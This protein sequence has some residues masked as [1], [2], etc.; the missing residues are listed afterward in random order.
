MKQI[1]QKILPIL[2]DT[3]WLGALV[4]VGSLAAL[5]T[6]WT[7]QYGFG[8][9]PCRLCYMQRKPYMINIL[10]G[11]VVFLLAPKDRKAAM[12]VLYVSAFVFF[13]NAVIAM[14]HVGVERQWWQE[15]ASCVNDAMPQNATAE[16][17]RKFIMSQSTVPCNVISF[18]L[19]GITM[20]GYNC[21]LATCLALGTA[22]FTR[23]QWTRK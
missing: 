1:I 16:E 9:E 6:A 8:L 5:C 19:F 10:L 15:I 22:F 2:E 21:I 11:L 3:R 17:L 18:E 14:H 20:P 4:A 12:I 23:R 13:A 7:A